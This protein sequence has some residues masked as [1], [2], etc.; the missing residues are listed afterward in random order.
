VS[1]RSGPVLHAQLMMERRNNAP[2]LT[3]ASRR[4]R[5][6][7]TN[8]PVQNQPVPVFP[9]RPLAHL[10]DGHERFYGT[11]LYSLFLIFEK[12]RAHLNILCSERRNRM[13]H[14]FSTH[15]QFPSE[16]RQYA[17]YVPAPSY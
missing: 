6:S 2:I 3:R 1:R 5:S 15:V 4:A 10:H 8:V 14:P 12:L 7:A 16:P 17:E 11:I 9:S 13:V